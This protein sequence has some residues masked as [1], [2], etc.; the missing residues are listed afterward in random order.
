MKT[1]ISL[2][3]LTTCIILVFFSQ[4]V[5]GEVRFNQERLNQIPSAMQKFVDDNV[6]SG[7][8]VL[9]ADKDKVRFCES[10]G[11]SD[12]KTKRKMSKDNIFWI[13]SMTKPITAVALMILVDE[14]KVSVDDPVE[15]YLPEFK[16]QWMIE[17]KTNDRMVLVKPPRP[18]T[19]H[20]LLTHTSGLGDLPAP[21]PH[22]TLAELVMAYSQ[23]P[24]RFPP[25]SKW[26]YSN[27]GINTVGRIVEVVSG[28][29][30]AD[31]VEKRI[32]KPLGMKNTTFWLTKSQ[33]ERVAKSYEPDK[34]TGGLKE[35]TVYFI[36]GDLTD[37]KRTPFPAGGLYS[38]AE[39]VCK[40]YQMALNKGVYN[41][42]R[43]LSEAAINQMTT[44][45]T[46]EIKTGFTEG[47][48]YGLGF[49]V[50]KEPQ[51][52][53]GMLSKGTFGHGGAYG[54]ESWA[55]PQKGVIYI[56]MIQRA[57]LPNADA[58]DI[59]RV[60]QQTAANAIE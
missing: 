49:A 57:K 20:D 42:K 11:Y 40:F 41:G 8:V 7:A 34:T 15:K 12:L 5:I 10:V 3:G 46:G 26:E 19:I 44:T 24:L 39:D 4:L 60:F 18:I 36:Q 47:M 53:T 32:F 16:N 50:V 1:R 25:G 9:V 55:D 54:T 30:Y 29:P 56:L 38:T 22:C 33:V 48:S 58:S 45:Q 21:R 31:F 59:R 43:I 2:T 35:T 14:G 27:A 28:I 6:I 51:G 23:Q 17:E 52:V 13:A 37:K